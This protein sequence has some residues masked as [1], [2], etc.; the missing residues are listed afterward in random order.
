MT[1]YGG[2]KA[3]WDLERAYREET[4]TR[5]RICINGLWRFKPAGHPNEPCPGF[6]EDWGYFKVPGTWP[7][8]P[9]RNENGRSQRFFGPNG[10]EEKLSD[11]QMAWYWREINVPAQWEG[12]RIAL[13]AGW[14]NSRARVF[15]DGRAAGKVDFPGGEID[16]TGICRPGVTHQL[17]ILVIAQLLTPQGTYLPYDEAPAETR[18]LRRGLCG[19]VFLMSM[20]R[21]PRISDVGIDTSVR[22][23]SITFAAAL[24]G[25]EEGASYALRARVLDG[26][27]ETLTAQSEPFSAEDLQNG[28][29]E[30]SKEWTTPKL[31]DTATPGNQYEAT[32]ELLE[33]GSTQDV[34]HNVRFGFREFWIDGRD[35]YLNGS[36]IFL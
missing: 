9:G 3:V 30:F 15:I 33:G 29:L 18:M 8:E 28:R 1:L 12:R 16:L 19:D 6:D 7:L 20:P 14:V 25:L 10:W 13:R 22:Q 35:F 17:A 4:A 26:E 32:I 27:E 2:V 11:V 36:R 31:W 34:C 24:D 21:G 23:W 5:E